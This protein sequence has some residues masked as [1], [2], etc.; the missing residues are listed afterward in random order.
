MTSVGHAGVPAAA[1][2]AALA[3]EYLLAGRRS[4]QT[5]IGIA[6]ASLAGL[7]E[8]D[9][10]ESLI[11]DAA[12]LAFWIDVYNGAAMRAV[13]I[14]L[15]SWRERMRFM[16]AGIIT[17]AGTRLSLG[18]IEFGIL[19]RSQWRFGLGYVRS[20]RVTPFEARH[21][22]ERLDP[23]VH[24]AL[25]CAAA[26][27]PPIAAY[28]SDRIDEQLDLATRSYLA[29][30]V[31]LTE[32]VARVPQIFLW[33]RGDFREGGGVRAFMREHGVDV[34]DR[35]LRFARYDWTPAPGLWMPDPESDPDD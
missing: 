28:T 11:D 21:R 15:G 34:G 17:V 24:F 2:P 14:R 4:D 6:L 32:A 18:E 12:R 31:E 27:C 25:N 29:G 3:H 30:S 19:R 9:L 20:R 22:V 1:G 13:D 26:S 10:D 33:F 7:T 8:D 5:A 23:R 35:K 16:H